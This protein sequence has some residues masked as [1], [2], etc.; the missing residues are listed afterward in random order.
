MPIRIG[1]DLAI[2]R[3][4]LFNSH[5]EASPCLLR[6]SLPQL[7][8]VFL[9]LLEMWPKRVNCGALGEVDEIA[10]VVGYVLLRQDIVAM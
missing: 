10:A 5:V 6:Q 1:I 3:N 8:V 7:G 4:S 9:D 2:V